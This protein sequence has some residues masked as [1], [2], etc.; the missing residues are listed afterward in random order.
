MA[1]L[2]LDIPDRFQFY[3][4]MAVRI[5]D[6]NYGKHLGNDA[7]LSMIHE[8]RVRFLRHH[9]FPEEDVGGVGIIM[10][11]VAILYK[12]ECFYGDTLRIGVGVRDIGKSGCDIVYL[13]SHKVTGKEVARAKTGIVFFDYANRKVMEVPERFSEIFGE[14]A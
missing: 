8:A 2:K 14:H 1:R 5:T 6:L 3:T 11:D 13:I 7:L 12:A 10:T 9:G 4:E